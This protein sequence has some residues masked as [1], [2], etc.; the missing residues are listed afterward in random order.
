MPLVAGIIIFILGF[1]VVYR[2]LRNAPKILAD[3]EMISFNAASFPL[4][5]IK[6]VAFTSKVNFPMIVNLPKEA[7]TIFFE[8]GSKKII[9]D[10]MYENAWEI[11]L[12]LKHFFT[13][14]EKPAVDIMRE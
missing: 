7:A 9:Y 6:E 14:E 10:D 4:T 3:H 8:D 13:D 12:Y 2:Y 1:Y 5:S 11:K